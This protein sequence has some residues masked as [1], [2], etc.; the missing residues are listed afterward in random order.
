MVE[1]NTFQRCQMASILIEDDAS[2]WFESGPVRDLTIRGNRFIGCGI[3]IN[4]HASSFVKG[5]PVHENIRVTG[6]HFENAGVEARGTGKVDDHRQYF[7]SGSACD[8]N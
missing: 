2:G 7:S 6:N 5:E 1:G 4:P 8:A 3:Q